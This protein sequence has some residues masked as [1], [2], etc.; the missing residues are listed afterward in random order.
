MVGYLRLGCYGRLR[1]GGSIPSRAMLC[2]STVRMPE[3][4]SGDVGSIPAGAVIR[5]LGYA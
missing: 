4:G 3:S 5:R 1:R 2:S